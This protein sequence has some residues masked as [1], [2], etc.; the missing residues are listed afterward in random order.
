MN[1]IVLVRGWVQIVDAFAEMRKAT[2]SFVLSDG[3]S[4]HLC[5]CQDTWNTWACVF[6]ESL[7]RK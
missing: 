2:F 1:N 6:F 4:D 3:P 5:A 7:S